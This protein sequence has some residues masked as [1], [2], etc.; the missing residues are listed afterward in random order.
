MR[1]ML[2]Y[3]ENPGG[4][5]SLL[6][7][8]EARLEDVPEITQILARRAPDTI[9]LTEREVAATLPH[10]E[11]VQ[12]PL[13]GV[14]AVAA[15][16]PLDLARAEL[17]SLAVAPGWGGRGLGSWLVRRALERARHQGRW[18]ACVTLHPDF[19]ARLGFHQVPL[20]SLP[21]KPHRGERVFGRPRIAM[22]AVET[23]RMTA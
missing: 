6:R 11:V 17:G 16:H 12:H 9:P 18:L 13:E 15:V 8:G 22:V 3:V 4:S 1:P 19:F 7:A 20:D 23:V 21:R 14:V 10:F 5:F 2:T